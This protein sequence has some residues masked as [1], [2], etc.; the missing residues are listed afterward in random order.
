[1]QK[2]EVVVD[3]WLLGLDQFTNR[4]DAISRESELLCV[5]SGV[6]HDDA[7]KRDNRG[8]TGIKTSLVSFGSTCTRVSASLAAARA[9]SVV[10][11]GPGRFADIDEAEII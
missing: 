3:Q 10:K 5:D 2:S 9:A 7:D 11:T 4:V 1:M 6:R 8:M